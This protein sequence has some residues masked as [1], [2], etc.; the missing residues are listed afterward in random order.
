VVRGQ[1]V[2]LDSD[3]AALYEVATG[4][5]NEVVKRNSTRFPPDFMWTLTADE[6]TTLRSQIATLKTGQGQRGTA[7]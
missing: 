2:L 3:L 1:K 6:W 4:R 7:S 5:F